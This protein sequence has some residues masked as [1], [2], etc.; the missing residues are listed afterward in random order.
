MTSLYRSEVVD[1]TNDRL[2]AR[3]KERYG[4][5]S[6]RLVTPLRTN[7]KETGRMYHLLISGKKM[8]LVTDYE[9]REQCKCSGHAK[10]GALYLS[11]W[12]T[13]KGEPAV[14]VKNRV[15]SLNFKKKQYGMGIV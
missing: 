12:T 13:M 3:I 6:I 5:D 2:A 8:T 9:A 1:C 7:G 11:R 15:I 10:K 4:E 14:A